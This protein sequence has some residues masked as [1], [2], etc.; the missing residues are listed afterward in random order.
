MIHRLRVAHVW[1]PAG[2]KG[3][4]LERDPKYRPEAFTVTGAPL[5]KMR[6]TANVLDALAGIG[7]KILDLHVC[8]GQDAAFHSAQHGIAGNSIL[9]RQLY[10]T[11]RMPF[12]LPSAFPVVRLANNA[13]WRPLRLAWVQHR[14]LRNAILN[15][16]G[17]RAEHFA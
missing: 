7:E 14:N 5:S 12:A 9:R 4:P 10:H 2:R 6:Q 15:C 17:N 3:R 11:L 1:L 8:A 13:Y 16:K